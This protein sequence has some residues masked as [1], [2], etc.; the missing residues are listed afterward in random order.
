MLVSSSWPQGPVVLSHRSFESE[1]TSMW[2]GSNPF[3]IIQAVCVTN[4]GLIIKMPRPRMDHIPSLPTGQCF[5]NGSKIWSAF[6]G[7]RV[8]KSHWASRNIKI[9]EWNFGAVFRLKLYLTKFFK[10][11]REAWRLDKMTDTLWKLID[12]YTMGTS[13]AMKVSLAQTTLETS[14]GSLWRHAVTIS[15]QCLDLTIP[16][17]IIRPL[18]NVSGILK[19]CISL[20]DTVNQITYSVELDLDYQELIR[21]KLPNSIHLID[22]RWINLFR[23]G[24]QLHNAMSMCFDTNL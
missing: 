22:W 23:L 20:Y 1:I 16:R 15:C 21:L 8:Q 9:L 11:W 24:L 13:A 3:H 19:P 7:P 18:L 2:T 5:L 6:V 4:N 17:F 12:A 10:T 14:R